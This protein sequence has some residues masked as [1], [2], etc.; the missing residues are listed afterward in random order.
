M[1]LQKNDNVL[2]EKCPNPTQYLGSSVGILPDKRAKKDI[3]KGQNNYKIL[4]K[5][6]RGITT[7]DLAFKSGNIVEKIT[8]MI[9]LVIGTFWACYFIQLQFQIWAEQPSI[10][11]TAENVKLSDLNYPAMTICSKAVFPKINSI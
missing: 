8:W 6:L 9:I 7:I 10:V 3:K 4:V 11:T 5:E 1:N 2:E